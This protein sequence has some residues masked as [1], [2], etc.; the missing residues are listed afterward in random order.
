MDVYENEHADEQ[1]ILLPNIYF[2]LPVYY[3][4]LP[5]T[6]ISAYVYDIHIER[7]GMRCITLQTTKYGCRA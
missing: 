3:N 2:Y 7:H 5:H 6:M 1:P 4:D